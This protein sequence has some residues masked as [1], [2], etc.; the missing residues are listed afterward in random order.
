LVL[1][2][3]ESKIINRINPIPIAIGTESPTIFATHNKSLMLKTKNPEH[4]TP[5]SKLEKWIIE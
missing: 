3:L 4:Q 2:E 5:N 1:S